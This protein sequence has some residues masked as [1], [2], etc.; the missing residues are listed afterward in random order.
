MNKIGIVQKLIGVLDEQ[1]QVHY[2]LPL[3][4]EP[5]QINPLIG[6]VI[7][8]EFTGKVSCIAC[9]RPIKKTYS[10]GYCY[11]C[12]TT[13]AQC[14]MCILKPEQCH[15]HLGTCRE[16]DW[17]EQHCMQDHYVYL[18]NASSV[19][20]G[21]T[22]AK[23]I[24]G[25]WI[26]QGAT[27]A[28]PIFKVRTRRI[29]GLIEVSIKQHVSDKTNWRKMLSGTSEQLDLAAKRDE[30]IQLA[31][32]SIDRVRAEFGEDSVILLDEPNLNIHF[33][34]LE[35]PS[36]ITSCNFDKNPTV[37]GR[38][39]GIKGQ[40]LIFDCGVL[41]IRKYTGYELALS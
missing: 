39:L 28:M 1:N 9:N 5:V 40:Y 8:L 26:D 21:I 7:Q 36:K 30:L 6:E 38:L 18:S 4:D 15:F 13:L 31:Q 27:Q 41:N 32:P 25:R 35:Y 20:V 34:V 37:R 10:Q 24:P 17:G 33:P 29:S 16:P 22:R 14:D 3:N 2:A 23:N 11:V 12:M 19:K